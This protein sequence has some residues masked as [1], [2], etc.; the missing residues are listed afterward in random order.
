MS[1]FRQAWIDG[2]RNEIASV[3]AHATAVYDAILNSEATTGAER[4]ELMKPHLLRLDEAMAKI[5]L[6]LRE[7]E[8]NAR[9]LIQRANDLV[10]L[11]RDKPVDDAKRKTA[12][13]RLVEASN[14]V[15]KEAWERVKQGEPVFRAAKY[16]SGAVVVVF[17]IV[18]VCEYVA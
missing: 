17:L 3:V 5:R 9:Q 13:S 2:L 12:E 14:V 7:D 11:V 6:R 8:D 18:G 1:E 15:L 10:E 4:H 16:L